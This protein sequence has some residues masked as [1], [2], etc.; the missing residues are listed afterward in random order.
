M[1]DFDNLSF[2]ATPLDAANSGVGKWDDPHIAS[3]K[4]VTHQLEKANAQWHQQNSAASGQSFTGSVPSANLTNGGP[5][6]SKDDWHLAHMT[7]LR[8]V[9]MLSVSDLAAYIEGP[10]QVLVQTR[11]KALRPVRLLRRA[12]V[13]G[14]IVTAWL[15]VFSF[16]LP[17]VPDKYVFAEYLAARLC[18][19][20]S[21]IG[22][23]FTSS[24]IAKAP[25]AEEKR[26]ETL[27][28]CMI[29][30]LKR[31]GGVFRAGKNFSSNTFILKRFEVPKKDLTALFL[32]ELNKA[33]LKATGKPMPFNVY[34]FRDP[35]L[36][37]K[38]FFIPGGGTPDKMSAQLA[39]PVSLA[40]LERLVA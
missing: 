23:F 1:N 14:F 19:I 31:S 25:N 32:H 24:R 34:R 2:G 3:A 20:L 8:Q 9:N 29:H 35:R 36:W 6:V 18:L 33:V 39:D 21:L 7:L 15:T 12:A 22:I 26:L 4:L 40:D 16:K 13:V 30:A 38:A 37:E 28:Q 10:R 5:D 17:F 11:E 27:A